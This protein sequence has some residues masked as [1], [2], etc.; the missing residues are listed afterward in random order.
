VGEAGAGKSRL[1]YEFKAVLPPECKLLE[2]YSVSHGKASAYLP[3]LTLLC[4]YFD[5]E[6]SD[7]KAARR[8]KIQRRLNTLDPALADTLPLIF[9]LMDL[10][11]G[12]DPHAQMDPQIKRRRTLDAIKRIILRESLNQTTIVL[13]EDLHWIDGETQALLD[14]LADAIANARILLLINYRPEYRHGWS[15][16]SYYSQLRLDALDQENSSAMLATLLGEGMKLNPLKR[17]IVE[18]TEG[19]PFFIEEMVRALFD[20]GALVRNGVVKVTRSLSQLRL[21]PTVQGILASRIDRLSSERKRLLQTLAVMGREAPLGLIKH[22]ASA[23]NGQL[24]RMLRDLQAGEFIYEQPASADIEYVFKH[25]LTQ[26]VAYKSLLTERRKLLHERTAQALE[27]VFADNLDDHLSELARHYS[28]SDN[29][30]SAIEY[31]RRAGQRALRR[32][33]HAEGIVHFTDAL[34]SLKNLPEVPERDEK[35]LDLQIKL[36]IC[37]MAL[38]G[39]AAPEVTAAFSRAMQLC[40]QVEQRP[41]TISVMAGMIRSN[42]VRGEL[43][44]ARELSEQCLQIAEAS[45]QPALQIPGRYLLERKGEFREIC[46]SHQCANDAV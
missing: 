16:K 32:S 21:P 20:E 33:A 26:E 45:G 15:N 29:V 2:A 4:R 46:I 34:S 41:E 28:C 17:M 31:L 23:E 25:A 8:G 11:E 7:D 38:K 37:Y 30:G 44:A 42:Y 18:R 40:R 6:E 12:G 43:R 1:I 3:V 22:V 19:N 9:A 35:E 27:S 24:E 36:G 39:Y 14:L 5:V 10:H 13:F